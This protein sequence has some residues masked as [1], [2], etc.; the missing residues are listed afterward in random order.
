MFHLA[1]A[2]LS[3]LDLREGSLVGLETVD[4]L[5]KFVEQRHIDGLHSMLRK[6]IDIFI[7]EF[8]HRLFS[9]ETRLFLLPFA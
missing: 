9:F 1:A 2:V 6:T 3:M 8:N 5:W 4:Y 7:K